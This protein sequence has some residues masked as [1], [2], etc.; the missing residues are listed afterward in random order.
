MK[1]GGGIKSIIKIKDLYIVKIMGI[2][3]KERNFKK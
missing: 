3:N 2:F 1:R